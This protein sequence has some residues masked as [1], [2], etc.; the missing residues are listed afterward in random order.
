M[1]KGRTE[2]VGACLVLVLLAFPALAEDIMPTLSFDAE[3]VVAPAPSAPPP[4]VQPVAEVAASAG[5][6][7]GLDLVDLREKAVTF[8]RNRAAEG[9]AGGLISPP[10]RHRVVVG[11]TWVEARFSEKMIDVDTYETVM[12]YRNVKVGESTD[13][14]MVRKKVP[15]KKKAGKEKRLQ[16]VRDPNGDIVGRIAKHDYGPGGPDEWR[17][18]QF[19]NNAMAIY[20]M[21]CA[22][23]DS[24]D[25]MVLRVA[26]QLRDV[27]RQ[28]GLPDLTWDLAW[29]TAAFSLIDDPGYQELAGKMAG[30]LL[31]GQIAGG[32]A[33]GLWGPVCVNTEL[34]AA[35]MRKRSDYS[36]FYLKAKAKHAAKPRKLYEEKAELALEALRSFERLIPRVSMLSDSMARVS[37]RIK[38]TDRMDAAQSI[39]IPSLPS[40]LFTQRSADMEST[41]AAMFGLQTAA[42][43][44]VMPAAT[45]RPKDER[46]RP[47]IAP[48]KAADILR[49]AVRAIAAAQAK[50]GWTELN[51]HLPVVDF[52][53]IEGINGVP[54][55]KSSFKPLASPMNGLSTV[56]GY[57][58]F[59]Y[60]ASIYGMSGIRPFARNVVA[61]NEAVKEVLAGLEK[62]DRETPPA[63]DL[64]FFVS[65]TPDLGNPAYDLK[66]HDIISEYLV[67]TQNADGSW[68]KELPECMFKVPSSLRERRNVLPGMY[69]RKAKRTRDWSVAHVD[70]NSNDMHSGIRELYTQDPLV[71][72]TAYA[73]MALSSGQKRD[74]LYADR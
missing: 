1:T 25:E 64:C 63:C 55:D 56:Q 33:A 37:A 43:Q 15:I 34:L 73:L 2:R 38:L 49:R 44:K 6:A 58:V 47:L 11:T 7:Q 23:V 66:A 14:V 61:G 30:K 53:E 39:R 70:Y 16:K 4:A 35:M 17:A 26:R 29:S 8:F 5:V 62:P 48:R 24:Q 69:W 60:Y 46:R 45:W 13:A 42:R 68:G 41:A 74:L 40:W 21:M 28:Y 12:E 19:G 51:H 20:A 32:A 71:V 9:G 3:P 52:D 31:D 22:G 10:I 50:E 54:I 57:A 67:N 27:Y 65:E 36:A 18:F 59:S 72:T